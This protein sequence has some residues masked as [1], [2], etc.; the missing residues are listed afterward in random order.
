[1]TN[2]SEFER[3]ESHLRGS[4]LVRGVEAS[5]TAWRAA[6]TRSATGRWLGT[7]NDRFRSRT[8]ADRLRAVAVFVTTAS[9][10]HLLLLRFVLPHIAPALPKATWMLV[11]AAS[12]VVALVPGRITSGWG[13]SL[14]CRLWRVTNPFN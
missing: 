2:G 1:M 5:A 7:V 13:A 3:L 11:A 12:L 10:G 6:A 14:V 8:A 9:I 4:R